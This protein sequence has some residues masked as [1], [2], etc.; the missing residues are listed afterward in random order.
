MNKPLAELE[1]EIRD[2]IISTLAL[3]DDMSNELESQTPLFG[4]GLGLDS[5]DALELGVALQKKYGVV[6]DPKAEET[7]KHFSCLHNI[8]CLV[9]EHLQQGGA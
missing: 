4:D 7:Q 2:F 6:V 9:Q 8:T 5:V 3:D 1:S